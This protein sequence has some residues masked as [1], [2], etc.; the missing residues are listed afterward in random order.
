MRKS[1]LA[2]GALAT[3]AALYL[4]GCSNDSNSTTSTDANATN[5]TSAA[6]GDEGQ[7]RRGQM[8]RAR[9]RRVWC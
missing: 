3:T 1:A 2:L 5:A 7:R 8:Q 9:S 4:T 6:G